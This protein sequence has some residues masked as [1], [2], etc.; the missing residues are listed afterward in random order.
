MGKGSV[1]VIERTRIRLESIVVHF[2]N[3]VGRD[4]NQL[5]SITFH[6]SR[7]DDS[8]IYRS[9]LRQVFEKYDDETELEA[10]LLKTGAKITKALFG[11]TGSV[12]L[13][14][15]TIALNNILRG[16][17][18]PP[19]AEYS[20]SVHGYEL[21]DGEVDD[22]SVVIVTNRCSVAIEKILSRCTY[23]DRY[24]KDQDAEYLL[25]DMST[26]DP[27]NWDC[28]RRPSSFGVAA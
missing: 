18:K 22:D 19:K 4:C 24:L 16:G 5:W 8:T 28:R 26:D 1:T 9:D 15:V 14:S 25:N 3:P 7:D 20:F 21:E 12:E 13:S 27:C 11:K 10:E 17:S 6:D 23:M 2:V